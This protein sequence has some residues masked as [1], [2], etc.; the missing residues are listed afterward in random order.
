M[1]R[2][3]IVAALL[4]V[5]FLGSATACN[6]FGGDEEEISQ[7][8]VEVVRGDL[9]LTVSGSGNIEIADDIDLAFDIGG[10]IARINVEEGDNV[11]AGNVL[12]KLDTTDLELALAQARVT[13]TQAETALTQAK[14]AVIQAALAVNSANVSLRTARHN[15]D[16]ARDLYTWPPINVARDNLADAEAFLQYVLDRG[17][18]AET[19][20]YAQSRV[21]AAKTTLNA[22]VY[23]YDTEEV[24]IKKME[25]TVA[26]ETLALSQQSLVY[27][28]QS[29]EYARQSVVY[30]QRS[31]E[32]A[33]KQ[34]D[35]AVISAPFDG[36]VAKLHTKE[37]DIIPPPTLA[38]TA[39]IHLI[40]PTTMEL[41]AEVDEIDMP[42]VDL[43][44]RAIIEVDAL[45]DLPLEGKVTFISS[46]SKEEAGVVLY[47]VTVSFDIPQGSGLRAGMSADADIVIEERNNILLVPARAVK[48]DSEGNP[49]VKVVVGEETEERTVIIGISDGFDTEIVE[50]LREGKTVEVEV[51][52]KSK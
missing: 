2:W 23:S 16:E 15:L 14:V 30:A 1:R 17:L 50:G 41:N 29:V 45:P 9:A 35:K 8:L 33:Q 43:N 38:A 28:Q 46:L 25:I 48:Q 34:L 11:A 52:T 22:M 42:G 47:D 44:Q 31:L 18:S 13:L 6:P 21:D 36:V 4:M 40:D 3:G 24:A 26:E 39:I 32:H 5:L 20:L 19:L 37:G 12:A 7:R 51:R 49:I 10:R 27:A